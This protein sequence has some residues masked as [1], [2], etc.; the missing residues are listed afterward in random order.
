MGLG[1][2][3]PLSARARQTLRARRSAGLLPTAPR[4]A[5]ALPFPVGFGRAPPGVGVKAPTLA[6]Q[7][8]RLLVC[9]PLRQRRSARQVRRP[10]KA[11]HLP[12]PRRERCGDGVWRFPP[13]AA[14]LSIL[15]PPADAGAFPS[16]R[17]RTIRS[18][19]G[20]PPARPHP[21]SQ[22]AGQGGV[23]DQ[24]PASLSW[25][26]EEPRQAR[27]K[28]HD[29]ASARHKPRG[30][31]RPGNAVGHGLVACGTWGHT[32]VVQDKTGTRALGNARRQQYGVPG[33]PYL[34]AEPLAEAVVQAVFAALAPVAL[35][36][37]S[38]AMPAQAAQE[39]TRPPAQQHPLDRLQAPA[40]LAERQVH[41]G[42][43]AKRRVAAA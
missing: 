20:P 14:L 5:L 30:V 29:A 17:P 22:D 37:S 26:T 3:G 24:Y 11:H 10:G 39:K 35:D 7:R 33:W 8:R 27:R 42:A 36:A 19:P 12:R 23:H 16:G 40:A 34:P 9:E 43:P 25:D 18:G 28:D 1:L 21:V 31:P 4:G 15:Q 41:R 32:M 6:V 38:R 2:K 13:G